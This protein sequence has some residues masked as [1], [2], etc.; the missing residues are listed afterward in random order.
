MPLWFIPIFAYLLFG[1]FMALKRRVVFVPVA[2]CIPLIL[3]GLHIPLLIALSH[4]QQLMALAA[5]LI[6]LGAGGTIGRFAIIK[7][8]S[9]MRFEVEG[10]WLTLGLISFIFAVKTALGIYAGYTPDAQSTCQLL[11]VLVGCFV[12]GVFLG[13]AL[14]LVAHLYPSQR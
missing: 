14:F 3:L 1:G 11:S 7:A 6:G 5:L 9:N 2:L 8:F 4:E 10:E 13:R 12:P